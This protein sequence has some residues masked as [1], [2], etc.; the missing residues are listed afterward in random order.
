MIPSLHLV[1]CGA[2]LEAENEN[3]PSCK[4]SSEEMNFIHNNHLLLY[5]CAAEKKLC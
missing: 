5:M 3:C 4:I 1:R 2:H